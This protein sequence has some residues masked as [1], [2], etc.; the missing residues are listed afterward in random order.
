MDWYEPD[1][2]TYTL[3]DSIRS[4]NIKGKTVVDLGCSTGAITAVLEHENLVIPIDLNAKALEQISDKSPIRSDLLSGINQDKIDICIFN[5][6]YVP[7][8]ECPILGGGIHGRE[9]IDRFIADINTKVFYLLIIE[10][11]RPL[12]VIENIRMR[13]Y[14]VSVLNVRKIVGETVI[15]LKS[16][17]TQI[18]M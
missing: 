9:V 6:P 4:E 5:P 1:E 16:V 11:N 12:E 15:I 8:F 14:L 13:G 17:K 18:Q 3:I 2:D 7:D 10:A